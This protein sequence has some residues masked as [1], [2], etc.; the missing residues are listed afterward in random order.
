MDM[1]MAAVMD[2]VID[3]VVGAVGS[4]LFGLIV[5]TMSLLITT[6]GNIF[7]AFAG[8]RSDYKV[9][10]PE[11]ALDTDGGLVYDLLNTPLIKRLI[12]SIM[13][14]AGFLLII[15]TVMALAATEI[16]PELGIMEFPLPPTIDN[17][18]YPVIVSDCTCRESIVG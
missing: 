6:I 10:K 5:P 2:D 1:L 8:M 4:A 17:G 3:I 7:K 16:P 15:F 18:A 13:I 9:D 12:I 14:L 11:G